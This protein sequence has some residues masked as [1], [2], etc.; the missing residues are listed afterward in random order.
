MCCL[1]RCVLGLGIGSFGGCVFVLVIG[2]G[3]VLF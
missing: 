1:G 2:V 3:I